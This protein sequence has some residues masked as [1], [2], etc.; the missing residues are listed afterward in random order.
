MPMY[1]FVCRACGERF[2]KLVLSSQTRV[3]CPA[4]ESSDLEKQFSVFG[5]GGGGSK[6]AGSFSVPMGGG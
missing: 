6:S 3:G 4:C 5:M 1:E 2:E